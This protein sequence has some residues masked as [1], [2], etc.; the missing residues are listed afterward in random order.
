MRWVHNLRL[1]LR[2]LFRRSRVEQELN[3][4]LQFHLE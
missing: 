2:S 4:E 3:A 1:R